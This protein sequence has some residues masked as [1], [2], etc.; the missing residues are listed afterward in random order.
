MVP[1]GLRVPWGV[2]EDGC[3]L[4]D[5]LAD[6][7]RYCTRNFLLRHGTLQ[8]TSVM[9]WHPGAAAEA[10]RWE[11]GVWGGGSQG[12]LGLYLRALRFGLFIPRIILFESVLIL[13][14]SHLMRGRVL[15]TSTMR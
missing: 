13:M 6:W 4:T 8:V 10:G 15:L 3:F 12:A 1:P 5:R 14:M 2:L 7:M 11:C 9:V